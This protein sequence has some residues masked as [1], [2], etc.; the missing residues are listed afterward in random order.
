[1]IFIEIGHN[2]GIRFS[3]LALFIGSHEKSGIRQIWCDIISR[4]LS[5]SVYV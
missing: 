3:F 2:K 1:M 4:L 5:V